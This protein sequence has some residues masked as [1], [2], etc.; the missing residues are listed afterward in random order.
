[1]TGVQTCALPIYDTIE[2]LL[3]DKILLNSVMYYQMLKSLESTK[4][5]IKL[6]NYCLSA[7]EASFIMH[8][9]F[10]NRMPKNPLIEHERESFPISPSIDKSVSHIEYPGRKIHDKR[11]DK[12]FVDE[13][14]ILNNSSENCIWLRAKD[15]PPSNKELE[16]FSEN[17]EGT[18]QYFYIILIGKGI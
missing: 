8:I 15:I 17:Y 18:I 10:Q 11:A 5:M 2:N 16:L 12:N 9:I 6:K 4:H 13:E 3:N 14:F 7:F 1:M